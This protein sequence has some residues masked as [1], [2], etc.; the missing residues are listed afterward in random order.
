[1]LDV[2]ACHS[3]P[4]CTLPCNATEP[5]L[6]L[7][8][9][10]DAGWPFLG[11]WSLQALSLSLWTLLPLDACALCPMQLIVES[12]LCCQTHVMAK[13]ASCSSLIPYP[14]AYQTSSQCPLQGN[15]VSVS[16]L[17]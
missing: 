5:S 14:S 11:P 8:V 6:G 1:M 15:M 12:M 16:S 7:K 3:L 13:Q 9:V 17:L 4:R 2:V 10:P